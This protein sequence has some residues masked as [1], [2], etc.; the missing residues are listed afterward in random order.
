MKYFIP[1]TDNMKIRERKLLKL[2]LNELLRLREN[3][4]LKVVVQNINE[5]E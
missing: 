1:S 4:S 2:Y 3:L 5:K